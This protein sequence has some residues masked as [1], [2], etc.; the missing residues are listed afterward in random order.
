M[1]TISVEN[2]LKAIYHLQSRQDR[3]K[4]KDIAERLAV[5]LPSVSSMLQSLAS[6]GLVEHRPYKGARLTD[7]GRRAALAVIRKHRLIEMFLVETLDY[8]WDEVHAEAELLEHAVSDKL[9][10]HIERYLGNPQFDPHGDPIPTADGHVFYRDAIPL[11][12]AEP[13]QQFRL[14][15]VL[16]QAPDVLRHLARLGLR[17]DATIQVMEVLPFDGQMTLLVEDRQATVSRTLA[18]RLLVTPV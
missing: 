12:E 17:P 18:S 15:R 6:E 5:S 4:T 7:D 13:P 14:T 11:A 16:D 8:S 2:Y 3:V 1:P 10:A 9:A